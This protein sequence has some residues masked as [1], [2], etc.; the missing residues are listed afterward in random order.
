MTVHRFLTT[1][2][3]L[4]VIAAYLFISAHFDA[5]AE[6]GDQRHFADQ[7][8]QQRQQAAAIRICGNGSPRWLDERTLECTPHMGRGNSVVTAGVE[9]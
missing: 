3:A 8:V 7:Q 6:Q 9:L 1:L 2:M 5:D 4:F